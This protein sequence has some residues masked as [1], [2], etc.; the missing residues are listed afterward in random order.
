MTGKFLQALPREGSIR[1]EAQGSINGSGYN[2][3]SYLQVA[4]LYP[5]GISLIKT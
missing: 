3:G 2:D 1:H 4:A 5:V